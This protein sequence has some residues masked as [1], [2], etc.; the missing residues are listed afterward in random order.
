MAFCVSK[1]CASLLDCNCCG[2]C[3]HRRCCYVFKVKCFGCVQWFRLYF[4]TIFILFAMFVYISD[5][6]V[7]FVWY[8]L[9][10]VFEEFCYIYFYSCFDAAYFYSVCR[11]GYHITWVLFRN[12]VEL[13]K[14][15]PTF[16]HMLTFYFYCQAAHSV[17]YYVY[18]YI[19]A[20]KTR[21]VSTYWK[22]ES[23]WDYSMEN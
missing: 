6:L 12:S 15:I 19:R 17:Y 22:L 16:V 4:A 5:G 11:S 8:E 7:T 10:I 14:T 2:C 23:V 21:I 18:T 20:T 3:C 9:L 1:K 13:G